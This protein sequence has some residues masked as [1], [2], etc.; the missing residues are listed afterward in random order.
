MLQLTDADLDDLFAAAPAAP[1]AGSEFTLSTF[2]D[3]AKKKGMWAGAL[4]PVA[5]PDL[6][7]AQPVETPD[8]GTPGGGAG[9]AIVELSRPQAPALLKI[10]DEVMVNATDHAK[11]HEKGPAAQR[12]TAIEVTFD[13]AKGRFSV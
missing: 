4:L 7:G 13:R 11:G 6:I 8:G 9:L 12:V 3:H 10:Y 5:I 2:K 1:A